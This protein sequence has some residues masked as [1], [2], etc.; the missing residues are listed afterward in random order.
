M[1]FD[2]YS[3]LTTWQTGDR[4]GTEPTSWGLMAPWEDFGAQLPRE[5]TRIGAFCPDCHGFYGLSDLRASWIP[6]PQGT[7]IVR[8]ET[9]M[10]ARRGRSCKES[11]MWMRLPSRPGG[12]RKAP[13][14][15]VTC[16][17]VICYSVTLLRSSRCHTMNQATEQ[18]C[19]QYS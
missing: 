14:G 16:G 17:T 19:E 7:Q 15:T 3:P 5:H 9:R 8:P 2:V 13:C 4:Y 11:G 18:E 10:C 1:C 6:R 12:E